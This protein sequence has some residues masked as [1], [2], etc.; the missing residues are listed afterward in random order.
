MKLGDAFYRRRTG[1]LHLLGLR[2]WGK[3][4]RRRSPMSEGSKEAR[5]TDEGVMSGAWVVDK[6][7]SSTKDRICVIQFW[8]K[9]AFTPKLRRDTADR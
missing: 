2:A 3:T 7:G 5:P 9:N 1:Q 4:A 6:P 8:A